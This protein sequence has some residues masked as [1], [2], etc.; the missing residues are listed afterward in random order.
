MSEFAK[1]YVFIEMED[2]H[3][4]F[5]HVICGDHALASLGLDRLE[6]TY[7]NTVEDMFGAPFRFDNLEDE[8]ALL[9][10]LLLRDAKRRVKN[11]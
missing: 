4:P 6:V 11:G 2:P 8:K 9:N 3:D 7:H 10:L 1:V 5:T